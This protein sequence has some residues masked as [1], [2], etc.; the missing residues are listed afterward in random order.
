VIYELH[1]SFIDAALGTEVEVPTVNNRV[2]IKIEPGTQSGKI[3]RLRGK[4]IK[5]I[6]GYGIGDQLIHVNVW[7]PKHLS[8][9]ERATLESLRDSENFTPNPTKGEKGFFENMKEFFGA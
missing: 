4:G 3:L 2:K 9:D 8:K 5:D 6:E 1:V 7:T